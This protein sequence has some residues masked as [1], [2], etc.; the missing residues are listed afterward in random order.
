[1]QS[2]H[3][4]LGVK[5]VVFIPKMTMIKHI[6]YLKIAIMEIRKYLLFIRWDSHSFPTERAGRQD[7]MDMIARLS[8]NQDIKNQKTIRGT[9]YIRSKCLCPFLQLNRIGGKRE[10]ERRRE[11]V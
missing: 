3:I 10:K 4:C 7:F 8:I 1:M 2:G 6:T 5:N 9:R 11:W